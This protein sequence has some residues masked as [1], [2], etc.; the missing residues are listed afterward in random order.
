MTEEV[1][2]QASV[3]ALK[4]PQIVADMIVTDIQ[5]NTLL[6]TRTTKR[7]VHTVVLFRAP[8]VAFEGN[9]HGTILHQRKS[10]TPVAAGQKFQI[11]QKAI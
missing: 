6:V 5:G 7:W 8:N 11:K 9:Y 4:R 1:T 2:V 10:L 3:N